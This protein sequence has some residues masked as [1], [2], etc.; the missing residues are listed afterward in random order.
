MSASNNEKNTCGLC[1]D[2][3]YMR[4]VQSGRGAVFYLCQRWRSDP[5]YPKYPALPMQACPGYN[6][7]PA[8]TPKPCSK[9]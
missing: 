2:C 6:Q 3:A 4:R 5:A 1:A 9:P 7:T 8:L